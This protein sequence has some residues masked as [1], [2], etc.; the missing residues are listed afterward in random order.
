MALSSE[1]ILEKARNTR[2]FG[3]VAIEVVQK[4]LGILGG[5]VPIFIW[6]ELPIPAFHLFHVKNPQA[7]P[8]WSPP[9]RLERTGQQQSPGLSMKSCWAS[10]SL[11][12]VIMSSPRSPKGFM[13]IGFGLF[14]LLSIKFFG[15]LVFL[16]HIQPTG[17][18]HEGPTLVRPKMTKNH[19]KSK[20][21]ISQQRRRPIFPIVAFATDSCCFVISC[22]G[23]CRSSSCSSSSFRT[24]T[25]H[26]SGTKKM[27]KEMARI[28]W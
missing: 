9:K 5:E 4:K 27:E 23:C 24:S 11:L 8:P 18:L 13:A 12:P 2:V 16:T 17:S 22:F 28:L 25:S 15:Y 7:L 1:G 3:A 21:R 6:G 26:P 14:F 10:P 19:W 20:T